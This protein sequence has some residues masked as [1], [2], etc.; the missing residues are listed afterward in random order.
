M[1]DKVKINGIKMYF[2]NTL[3]LSLPWLQITDVSHKIK[4]FRKKD[5]KAKKQTNKQTN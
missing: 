1:N 5:F 4:R 3:A 2:L